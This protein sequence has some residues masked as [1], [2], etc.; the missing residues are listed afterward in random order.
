M[1]LV[2]GLSTDRL[3]LTSYYLNILSSPYHVAGLLRH[4]N[5][6]YKQGSI[7]PT[8]HYKYQ[9]P[10]VLLTKGTLSLTY[11]I[12]E[13]TLAASTLTWDNSG[14]WFVELAEETK[15]FARVDSVRVLVL[16]SSP[17]SVKSE[18]R[19]MI[20]RVICLV[21]KGME[22][23]EILEESEMKLEVIISAMSEC[24]EEGDGL[25]DQNMLE[26]D[27]MS[28]ARKPI[29]LI[30]RMA[31]ESKGPVEEREIVPIWFSGSL[32]VAAQ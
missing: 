8:L 21:R 3:S 20:N 11:E 14:F 29:W 10:L 23:A 13:P 15:T 2:V 12:L 4:H 24:F 27:F 22:E 25:E 7:A 31:E 9:S 32:V 26:E 28:N 5:N 30:K 19:M 1:P 6:P 18:I 17:Q 16:L